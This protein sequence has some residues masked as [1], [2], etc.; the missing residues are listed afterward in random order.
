MPLL[1]DDI[2]EELRRED[3]HNRFKK[4]L[5]WLGGLVVLILIVTAGYS[6]HQSSH[7][8]KLMQYEDL[9]GLAI[10]NMGKKDWENAKTQLEM[11]AK[12]CAGLRFLALS[13]LSKMHQDGLLQKAGSLP[14]AQRSQLLRHDSEI[15][16]HYPNMEFQQFLA[17]NRLFL[18]AQLKKGYFGP[19]PVGMMAAHTSQEAT[20]LS[21]DDLSNAFAVYQSSTVWNAVAIAIPIMSMT[22][23]IDQ[24]SA[25]QQ[26][27]QAFRMRF[28]TAY[29][30]PLYSLM[31]ANLEAK[32]ETKP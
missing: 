9:Y 10:Q 26:W 27:V 31:G 7:E 29:T 16:T 20:P 18:D 15:L 3:L 13:T 12:D 14:T 17:I 25:M 24:E 32:P 8:K 22:R 6:M 1:I 2:Q 11:V 21:K 4:A 23:G 5:P 30:L 19:A 28:G